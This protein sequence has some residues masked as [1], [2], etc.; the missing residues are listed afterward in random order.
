MSSRGAAERLGA[1]T[2]QV[3]D[4]LQHGA[5]RAV[6]PAKELSD[7]G[8]N[9]DDKATEDRNALWTAEIAKRAILFFGLV[10]ERLPACPG[11]ILQ[12]RLMHRHAVDAMALG[13][14]G[15]CVARRSLL[16]T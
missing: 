14:S 9:G 15:D 13:P 3:W 4:A 6:R 2:T 5:H 12:V 8:S 16:F 7:D 10:L 11:L 1:I